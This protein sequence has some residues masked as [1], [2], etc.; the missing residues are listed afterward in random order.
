MTFQDRRVALSIAGIFELENGK[1]TA[2]REYFDL[3]LM[4]Q[5]TGRLK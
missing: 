5:V 3:G 4:N 2:W 1:I